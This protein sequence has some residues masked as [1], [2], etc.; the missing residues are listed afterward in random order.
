MVENTLAST[1]PGDRQY[2]ASLTGMRGIAALLVFLFHYEAL[3]PGI[4]LDLSV[5]LIG[6]ILQFPLGFGFAGVDIFFVLSGFLL[7][8]PFA[9]AALGG[10]Q[11]P[12]LPG[13]FK[14]RFLRV[15]PAYYAQL[16]IIL[17]IGGWFV[18]WTP[19]TTP[20]LVAHLLMFF[21]IGWN[22]VS[23]M[24]GVWWTLPVEMGFYLLL[25][26]LAPFMRP[27]RWIPLLL[28]GIVISMVYRG[29]AAAHF[30]PQGG[31]QAF[32]TVSHLPGSLAEF[33]LGASA[34]RL[35]QDG[36][37]NNRPRPAAWVLDLMFILGLIIPAVWL[38]QVVLSAGAE[39]W[40]GHWGMVV[41][42]LALGLPLS[43]AVLG[44]YWGSRVGAFLLAN[45]VI[46]FL[47]LIS[48]SLYLWHFVIMQQLRFLIGDAYTGLPHWVT[49]PLAA[50]AAITVASASYYLVERPFYRLKS[51]S[52]VK[53]G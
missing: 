40:L 29:W 36:S 46:Y 12:R 50:A 33:L 28:G 6:S 13:Y 34:A 48:Y 8:L 3:H 42:P 43:M 7:T 19:Q 22:P 39:Y 2:I 37:L 53:G 4:R 51:F 30:G 17:A 38:W 25:P 16:F 20:L 9:R 41:G 10:K 21:N 27:G 31:G 45:R 24:V 44:L 23:P 1:V 47:G 26:L 32:L 49:F 5:P 18:T 11:A 14:R 15:F 35:V 52:Q